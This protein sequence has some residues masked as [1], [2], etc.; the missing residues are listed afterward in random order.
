MRSGGAG[1]PFAERLIG[2]FYV[3]VA[4]TP[5]DRAS[6]SAPPRLRYVFLRFV[7]AI[8]SIKVPVVRVV[9]IFTICAGAAPAARAPPGRRPPR[10]SAA[11]SRCDVASSTPVENLYPPSVFRRPG[12]A[13]PKRTLP[14]THYRSIRLAFSSRHKGKW[15]RTKMG[16]RRYDVESLMLLDLYSRA[17]KVAAYYE[18]GRRESARATLES[19]IPNSVIPSSGGGG[20]VYSHLLNSSFGGR[21]PPACRRTP[22]LALIRPSSARRRRAL[23]APLVKPSSPPLF[24]WDGVGRSRGWEPARAAACS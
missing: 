8:T 6:L 15:L 22:A 21:P 18:V 5:A 14:P 13:E 2:D 3:T 12:L 10:D 23:A 16:I 7:A 17:T 11:P 9:E 4:D 24:M 20:S 19:F 1:A